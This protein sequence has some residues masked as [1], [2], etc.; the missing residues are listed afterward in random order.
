M[1]IH[2]YIYIYIV[3]LWTHS[4]FCLHNTKHNDNVSWKLGTEVFKVIVS[5]HIL[6]FICLCRMHFQR[7][8]ILPAFCLS[9]P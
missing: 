6:S 1:E 4:S 8:P 3:K 5:G 7:K 2:T 9:F